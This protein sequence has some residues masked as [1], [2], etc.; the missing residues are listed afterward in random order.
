MLVS[1]GFRQEHIAVIT[2]YSEQKRRL[3]EKAKEHGWS[4]VKQIM[5][6]DS[7]QGDNYMI[8][9][10]SFFTTRNLV[11]FMGTRFQAYIDT[12]RQIKALYFVGQADYWF[13]DLR[14][15]SNSSTI[16]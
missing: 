10:I 9:F 15:V 4:G 2:G 12:S 5:T 16:S 14:E 6:I 1:V 3:T 8:V 13:S 7:S 11:G